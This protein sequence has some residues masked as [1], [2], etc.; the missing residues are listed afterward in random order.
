MGL[1]SADMSLYDIFKSLGWHEIVCRMANLPGAW[2]LLWSWDREV[3]RVHFLQ[4]TQSHGNY[5]NKTQRAFNGVDRHLQIV[6][7]DTIYEQSARDHQTYAKYLA[8]SEKRIY[9]SQ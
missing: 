4:V 7:Q 2:P 8:I 5:Q 9:Q 1:Q 3:H 6:I